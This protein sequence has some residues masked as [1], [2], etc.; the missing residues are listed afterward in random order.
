MA[1]V[2]VPEDG[3]DLTMTDDPDELIAG[4]LWVARVLDDVA[5]LQP[6]ELRPRDIQQGPTRSPRP[7]D[8]VRRAREMRSRL[9][10]SCDRG[11]MQ[12]PEL[13]RLGHGGHPLPRCTLRAYQRRER[14]WALGRCCGYA[15]KSH[16]RRTGA[17]TVVRSERE[18]A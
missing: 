11:R 18:A 3:D 6:A 8:I 14:Y 17:R 12:A 7:G 16:R 4:R 10:Q 9:F 5:G 2:R 1:I 15:R 13:L